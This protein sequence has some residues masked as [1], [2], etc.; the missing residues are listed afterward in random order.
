[1]CH[2]NAPRSGQHQIATFDQCGGARVSLS[3]KL[4]FITHSLANIYIMRVPGCFDSSSAHENKIAAA[5]ARDGGGQ[6]AGQKKGDDLAR[7]W[8][9]H[10]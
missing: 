8:I 3:A 2:S 1:M 10:P 4:R 5:R 7:K 6:T 9:P